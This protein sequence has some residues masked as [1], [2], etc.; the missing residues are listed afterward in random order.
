MDVIKPASTAV[1]PLFSRIFGNQLWRP[2]PTRK[3]AIPI[4]Q[5]AA[6]LQVG[7]SAMTVGVM[8]LDQSKSEYIS[9]TQEY[10]EGN[11][12][13]PRDLVGA[14][15]G[16]EIKYPPGRTAP[17]VKSGQ[18][19]RLEYTSIQVVGE[20]QKQ[21]T[22][23]RSFTVRGVLD[24]TGTGGVGV[25][26][27]KMVLIS[28]PAADAFFKSGG[29]Y[30]MIMVVTNDVSLNDRVEDAILERY[31]KDIGVTSFKALTETIQSFIAGFSIFF[32]SIAIIS[33]VVAGVGVIATLFTS[34]MERTR[35]IGVLKALGFRN[36]SIMA[37][38]ISEAIIIGI[39]GGA[40]GIMLGTVAGSVL[41]ETFGGI[42]MGI[43][44]VFMPT[45][46]AFVWL[47]CVAITVL[48][49]FYPAWRAAR[50]DAVASLRKE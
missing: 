42:T 21:V 22:Q 11:Y 29:K 44:P 10:L 4:I 31:G 45:D 1:Y 12:V 7:G 18:A 41:G 26:L 49:G 38:F 43:K 17:L 33:L 34:V 46:L 28:L 14:A 50:M 37:L 5:R 8:G 27:N 9:P 36:S 35:E 16:Y 23:K 3:E 20:E 48:A 6:K 47:F 39:I 25:N 30:D 19:I 32:L 40:I 2:F 13:Q 24:D 15:V